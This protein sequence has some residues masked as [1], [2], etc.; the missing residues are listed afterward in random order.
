MNYFRCPFCDGGL[1]LSAYAPAV[2]C[3]VCK[4]QFPI[5]R[6]VPRFVE[7]DE[8]ASSFA[9]QWNAH[10]R[11]QLDSYTGMSLSRDRL[12]K[13]SGW[14]AELIGERVLEAGSGAGRFTEV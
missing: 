5:I 9:F 10:Q 11:T 14:P 7:H 1:Q 3:L 6:G 8:Y 12:F 2:A 4:K 13:V